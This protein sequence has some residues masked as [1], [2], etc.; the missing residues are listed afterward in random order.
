MR[1]N[2]IKQRKVRSEAIHEKG[3]K[4]NRRRRNG[5]G[6]RGRSEAVDE[7]VG[8]RSGVGS[9]GMSTNVKKVRTNRGRSKNGIDP[10]I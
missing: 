1:F 2:V 10:T 4:R 6:M 5:K 8:K 3:R 7:G 9:R